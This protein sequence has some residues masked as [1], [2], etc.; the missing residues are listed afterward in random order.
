MH[1]VRQLSDAEPWNYRQPDVERIREDSDHDDATADAAAALERLVQAKELRDPIHHDDL[2]LGASG[3]A[4]PVES[5]VRYRT[6][7][8]ICEDALVRRVGSWRRRS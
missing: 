3:R 1:A 4:R 6:D 7:K 8:D 2:E 5:R